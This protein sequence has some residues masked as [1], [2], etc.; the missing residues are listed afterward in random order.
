MYRYIAGK[1]I[2]I[3]VFVGVRISSGIDKFGKLFAPVKFDMQGNIEKLTTKY[4][5]DKEKQS[6]LHDMIIL[7]KATGKN[8]IATDALMWLRRG[9]HMVHLFFEKI[10]EDHK[11]GNT[12]E[13]LGAFLKRSYKEALE[14]YH[15]WMAQQLFGLLSRM[16]PTRTQ[17]LQALA[18]E[19]KNRDDTILQ[20]LESFLVNLRENIQNLVTLYLEHSLEND[21][22][23]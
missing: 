6:T 8:L 17:L 19:Q 22:K 7:E 23:V 2:R 20:E 5:A 14:P 10:V 9:L 11:T 21:A 3:K 12:T 1:S 18:D 15:G 4:V 16:V 13:D